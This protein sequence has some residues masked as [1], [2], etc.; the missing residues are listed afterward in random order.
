MIDENKHSCE[1]RIVSISQSHVRPIV[2]G[3]ANAKVEF[4]AKVAISVIEGY[5]F[6]DNLSW[7][8]TFI[9]VLIIIHLTD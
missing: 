3:K 1:N 5:A 8:S 2:R 6:M 4:G 9:M 7:E